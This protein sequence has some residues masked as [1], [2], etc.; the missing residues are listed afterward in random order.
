MR[1]GRASR[2]VKVDKS[3]PKAIAQARALVRL[4]YKTNH[5][6]PLIQIRRNVRLR[7]L[8]TVFTYYWRGTQLPEDDAGRDCL[9]IAACHHWHSSS[10]YG[11]IVAI[12][13][14]AAH[15]AP[16]CGEEE[17]T[18]LINRVEAD[19]RKW[20]ADQMAIELNLTINL[21]DALGLTTIGAIDLDAAGR[22]QRRKDQK[23]QKQAETRRNAGMATRAEYLA[24][25]PK[26][27]TK[28]WRT[29]GIS[30]A[31]YYRR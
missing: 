5:R 24:S 27:R 17:L 12:K 29:M 9:W 2:F 26:S 31:T 14:W 1:G 7:E 30:R 10:R 21:R 8:E 23:R 4:L 15:W 6:I 20:K 16:W 22:S 18:A 25:N 11:P 19:P 28:P 3:N 13:T